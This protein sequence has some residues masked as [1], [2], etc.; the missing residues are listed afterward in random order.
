[1]HSKPQQHLSGGGLEHFYFSP[2]AQQ[3]SS[4]WAALA[5][6]WVIRSRSFFCHVY[7][8]G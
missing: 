7:P 3:P 4:G 5:D 2:V 1:M 6:S 8:V